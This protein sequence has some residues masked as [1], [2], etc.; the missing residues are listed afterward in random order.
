MV[1]RER[2]PQRE[3]HK[4]SWH[5]TH[6]ASPHRGPRTNRAQPSFITEQQA[7]Q[8]ATEPW[9]ALSA[10]RWRSYGPPASYRTVR[11]ARWRAGRAGHALGAGLGHGSCSAHAL[12]CSPRPMVQVYVAAPHGMLPYHSRFCV[13]I[14]E[15]G[16]N[17]GRA[18]S[19]WRWAALCCIIHGAPGGPR[20]ACR[21]QRGRLSPLPHCSRPATSSGTQG[22]CPEQRARTQGRGTAAIR[23]PQ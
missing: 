18:E 21:D 22:T 15:A 16:A 1:W 8:W 17:R 7:V 13:E 11:L 12:H 19:H 6:G 3:P 4:I 5:A 2:W 20:T 23:P 9:A 10:P 14:S